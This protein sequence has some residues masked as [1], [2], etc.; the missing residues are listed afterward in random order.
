M[1]GHI[2]IAGL[3]RVRNEALIIEDTLDHFGQFCDWIYVYDDAS[4]DNTVEICKA[5][6]KVKALIENKDW[7]K[8]RLRAEY[9]SRQAVLSV[10]QADNPAWFLYFDADERIEFDFVGFDDYD[11]VRMRLF[12]F[13]I[14][15]EDKSVAYRPG[16]KL[17]SLRKYCGP[18]FRSIVML[19]KNTPFLRYFLPDQREV[20]Y[21]GK[22]LD[23]GYVC[24]YG[25]SI[26]V[27]HWE[28]TCEYYS[29]Y[30]PK[31]AEKWA[32]RRGKAVHTFSDFGLPLITWDEKD[33]KGV[34][35]REIV[36]QTHREKKSTP[37]LL[38]INSSPK[39]KILIGLDCFRNF[40]GSETYT[41]TLV[42]ELLR[43]GHRVDIYAHIGFGS[44]LAEE[45]QDINFWDSNNPPELSP[46]YDVLLLM[47]PKPTE[48]LLER[49]PHVPASVIV[50]GTV[51]GEHPYISERIAKYIAVSPE[52]AG[53]LRD[54]FSIPGEK[55]QIVQNFIELDTFRPLEEISPGLRFL[56]VGTI[57]E[58]T[59]KSL[60]AAINITI[61]IKGS[62]LL[63]IGPMLKDVRLPDSE[64]IRYG[65]YRQISSEF[66]SKFNLIFA[67][68]RTALESMATGVPVCVLGQAGGDGIVTAE[69]LSRFELTNF[70]G[71]TLPD[72]YSARMYDVYAVQ[73]AGLMNDPDLF[74][75]VSNGYRKIIQKFDVKKAATEIENLLVAC[76]NEGRGASERMAAYGTD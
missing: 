1:A 70:S 76:I 13:Y 58:R 24:H 64:D 42:R 41:C 52:V 65:G 47:H 20:F 69:T 4:T 10:A 12:D 61:R 11:A 36:T 18:E 25:K 6:P 23:R 35:L 21:V 39:L 22:T 8:D 53:F 50:H 71:R 63:I 19:F 26:S 56:W 27:K 74:K 57:C 66:L 3:T 34:P 31:Y 51:K 9:T 67:V 45:V 5:H 48:F 15:P 17:E 7:D 2:R 32:S 29:Q 54:N 75:Q 16:M 28:E 72:V 38:D 55:I 59:V 46:A 68:G 60:E 33:L 37:T 62:N 43:R 14:T 40:T 44:P 49:F 30:F 73:I